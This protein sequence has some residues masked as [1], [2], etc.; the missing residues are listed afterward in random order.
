MRFIATI[1]KSDN[2]SFRHVEIKMPD[3]DDA[4]TQAIEFH[5]Q[6]DEFVFSIGQMD[7]DESEE[8]TEELGGEITLIGR[9]P[10]YVVVDLDN[11]E[12]THVGAGDESFEYQ[13]NDEGFFVVAEDSV[14]NAQVERAHE[15]AETE[16][17]PAWS[18][19]G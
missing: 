1:E 19:G 17:W 9:I 2:S 14:T 16:M 10:V 12:I 11:E 18:W 13:T 5:C 4:L 8:E 15:I 7:E 6:P 3:I